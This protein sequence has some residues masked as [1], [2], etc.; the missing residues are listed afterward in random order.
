MKVE[1]LKSLNLDEDTIQKIQ[2]ES[3]K[4]VTEAK[5]K[6]QTQIDSLTT[7][8]NDLTSQVTQ[9]DTD[10]TTLQQKLT[11]AGQSSAK[12]TQVQQDL[13]T[14]QSKYEADK[15]DWQTKLNKQNYEF[16][17]KEALSNIKFSSN[18]AKKEFLNGLMEK[19][20]P[21]ENDKL[22]GFEDYLNT[23]KQSDPGA[24]IAEDPNPNPKPAFTSP[25]NPTPNPNPTPESK[26]GFNF[27]GVR[28]HE[29]K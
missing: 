4:D 9:R 2:A 1:F 7:Q 15:T 23:Q 12:L 3:G 13:Q 22:L 5:T 18:A 29:Q 11:D 8:V 19:N 10:L 28:A 26:F 25:Q 27:I 24:F 21:V 20:L 14:L 16:L 6:L 17:A